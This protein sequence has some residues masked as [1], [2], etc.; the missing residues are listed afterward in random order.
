MKLLSRI[1]GFTMSDEPGGSL[2]RRQGYAYL[3]RLFVA[4]AFIA[5]VLPLVVITL[6]GFFQ[7]RSLFE[8][9]TSDK[10]RLDTQSAKQSFEFHI[11]ET[12]STMDVVAQGYSYGELFD[13]SKLDTLFIRLR[14]EYWW[15]VDLGTL[16]SSGVQRAYVGPY[17]FQG[18][19]YSDQEWFQNAYSRKTYVSD[20][21]TGYRGVPHFVVTVTSGAPGTDRYWMLRAS[22][23]SEHLSNYITTI[24][25]D[26]SIDM[27]LV[28]VDGTMR[29]QS[30]NHGKIGDVYSVD[31]STAGNNIALGQRDEQGSP[32]IV[33]STKL[34]G[35]P[36]ILVLE[37]RG[38]VYGDT[39]NQFQM[40]FI[41]IVVACALLALY[42]MFRVTRAMVSMIKRADERRDEML[43]EAQHTAKLAS[44]GQLAAGVAHEINNPLAIINEK[45]GLIRDLTE[46]SEDFPQR[47]RFLVLTDGAASAVKRCK[48]ITHRLLGFARRMEVEKEKLHINDV[49]REVVS[50]V[51]KEALYRDIKLDLVLDDTLPRIESDRGHLQQIFLNILNNALDA[52]EKNGTVTIATMA[53]KPRTVRTIITDTGP[54][55]PQNVIKHIFEPFFTTKIKNEASGTGLGLSIT[56]GIVKK[57]CGHISVESSPGEG[58]KFIIDFPIECDLEE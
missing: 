21:F 53:K 15:V 23:D 31:L 29:T 7:Y 26:D 51:E 20:I 44:V 4:A 3:Q 39:W 17:L 40:Q 37:R 30:R 55:I 14:N 11:Q 49:I 19:N 36:W 24:N 52:V 32:V 41:A 1:R 22:I 25:T 18:I 56:Y 34:E 43:A 58:A 5:V 54:G 13:Q 33:A 2:N 57:L 50:F 6:L 35:M 46:Y 16:D 12:L 8:R 27:F 47:D 45:I 28:G 38:Y 9:D 42:I 10:L 48:D